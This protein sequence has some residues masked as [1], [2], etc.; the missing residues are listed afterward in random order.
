MNLQQ[1]YPFKANS[2]A[3]ELT[4]SFDT[5]IK[6]FSLVSMFKHER[7]S[8]PKTSRDDQSLMNQH[9]ASA[10]ETPSSDEC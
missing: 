2:A 1:L 7:N 10:T 4:L 9:F 8:M 3:K 5:P 6:L